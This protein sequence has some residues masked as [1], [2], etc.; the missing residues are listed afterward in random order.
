MTLGIPG[1]E[2]LTADLPC[3]LCCSD[4]KRQLSH[5][6]PKFVFQH[7]SVRS[8]TGYLRTNFDPNRRKQDGPKEYLLCKVCERRLGEWERQFAPLFKRHHTEPGQTFDY[9]REQA[10]CALSIAWRV[11]A[12]SRAHPELNHLEFGTEYGRT[13]EA[14]RVWSEVLLGQRPHPG[15]YRLHWLFFN[16]VTNG[17]PDVNRYLFHACDFDVWANGQ[18]SFAVAHIPGL[19]IIG[20]VEVAP[21][22]TFRGFDVSFNGG[23]YIAQEG[24][25]A[26]SWLQTYIESRLE[27]RNKGLAEMSPQ[28]R[29]KIDQIVLSDPE[30][31]LQSPLFRA[32]LHDRNSAGVT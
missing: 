10:L 18:H 24:K 11:L 2:V 5:L 16:F 26:P 25:T 29:D 31:A 3:A 19:F 7:A 22:N 23:R 12:H 1:A 13:D 6:I 4:S 32:V 8:P 20:N 21:R 15:Q 9:T 17:P 14:F 30:R 28:Q 27:A